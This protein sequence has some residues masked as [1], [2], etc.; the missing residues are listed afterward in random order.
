MA[1]DDLEQAHTPETPQLVEK[2]TAN[3]TSKRRKSDKRCGMPAATRC[4]RVSVCARFLLL[5]PN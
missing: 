4:V 3:L 5:L 2:L 1:L